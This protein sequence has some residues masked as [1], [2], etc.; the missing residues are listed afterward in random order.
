MTVD[1]QEIIKNN[2]VWYCIDCGKCGAVCPISRWE[3]NQFTS[4]RILIE[5]S[6]QGRGEEVMDDPLFWSCLICQ[7]CTELCPSDVHFTEFLREARCLARG[8]DRV[9]DCTHSEMIQTWGRMM[10]NPSLN[11]NRLNWVTEELEISKDSDTLYFVGCL[12]YYDPIFKKIGVEGLAVAQAT[13]KIMNSMGIQPQILAEERCCGHDQ[14]WEGDF[15]TFQSLAQINIDLFKDLGV[16]RIVSACPECVR[17]LKIDYPKLA[18]EHGMEVLHITELL[19]EN[20]FHTNKSIEGESELKI[21]FQDPCN[22]GRHLGIYDPP[23]QVMTGAGYEVLEMERSR[24]AS[25]C[26]GTSCWRACGQVSKNV[27]VERLKEA[28]ATGADLLVT[29][30]IKCQIHLKCAQNDPILGEEIDIDI[31]DITT[32][33]AEDL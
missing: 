23:R 20:N 24:N 11:Q 31:R 2:R 28:I 18:G 10:T 6:I 21:T 1:L 8:L 26:C 29:A 33:L 17:T 5:K 14:F 9:G 32:I 15:E 4:P 25:L 16:K 30:C 3:R 13:V 19:V 22:L 12:P 7:R 27:Q